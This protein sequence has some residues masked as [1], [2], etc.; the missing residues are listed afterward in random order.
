M[1]VPEPC[2]VSDVFLCCQ[3]KQHPDFLLAL[4]R[5]GETD[6]VRGEREREKQEERERNI[7]EEPNINN[8]V[9]FHIL[10]YSL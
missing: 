5:C 4:P 8:K 1:R 3:R 2:V 7:W 6:G 9:G 10:E